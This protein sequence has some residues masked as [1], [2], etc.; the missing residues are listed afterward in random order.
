LRQL[1]GRLLRWHGGRVFVLELPGGLVLISCGQ[2][3]LKLR[4]GRLREC[5]RGVAVLW[6]RR[7]HVRIKRS[8]DGLHGLLGRDVFGAGR[9]QLQRE[10]QRGIFCLHSWDA[11]NVHAMRG[12]PVPGVKRRNKLRRLRFGSLPGDRRRCVMRNLPCGDLRA[13]N[14][15]IKLHLVCRGNGVY[16]YG[17]VHFCVV[18][19]LCGG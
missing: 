16:R 19:K 5:L 12:R 8:L 17:G 14:G 6:L 10:L 1:L 4:G 9:G 7:K 3:V 2:R 13:R 11:D 18:W 15:L